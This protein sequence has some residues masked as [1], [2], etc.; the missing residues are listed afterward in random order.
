MRGR[1]RINVTS[2]PGYVLLTLVSLSIQ[3]L[4]L[5]FD[6]VGRAANRLRLVNRLLQAIHTA[7]N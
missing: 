7:T 1:Y 4:D 3:D 2:Q 6:W 5:G